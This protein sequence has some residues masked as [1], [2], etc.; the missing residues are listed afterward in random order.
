M[1][2]TLLL[3]TLLQGDFITLTNNTYY[4]YY[5]SFTFGNSDAWMRTNLVTFRR[6]GTNVVEIALDGKVTL[7]AKPDEA[8]KAF[9]DALKIYISQSNAIQT[10]REEVITVLR[11]CHRY[12]APPSPHLTFELIVSLSRVE[13]LRKEANEIEAKDAFVKRLDALIS[14][15]T[16]TNLPVK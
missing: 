6:D 8:A 12:L 11:E 9:W 13:R 16:L 3:L 4:D 2:T 15:L 5:S 1:I 14:T 10:N 7:A